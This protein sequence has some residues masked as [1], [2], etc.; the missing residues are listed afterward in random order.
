[1]GKADHIHLRAPGNLALLAGLIQMLLSRKRKTV[2]YAGNWD[3]NAK[4]PLSYRL[5]KRLFSNP[6]WCKN[7]S[8]MAYGQW[9][10]QSKNIKPFFTATYSESEK[11]VY[12][13]TLQTPLQFLFVG[14]LSQNKNPQLLVELVKSLN[15]QGIPS[16]AHFYG[17]GPM[18]VELAQHHSKTGGSSNEFRVQSSELGSH[19]DAI[20]AQI[21]AASSE[22]R[23]RAIEDSIEPSSEAVLQRLDSSTFPLWGNAAGNGARSASFTFHGNQ[24]SNVVKKAYEN[25]HFIFLASQSEGWP[26]AIAE[27]MWHGCVPIATPVSCVPWMLNRTEASS[28]GNPRGIL[29]HSMEETIEKIKEL[30]AAPALF[31]QMSKDAQQWSQQ[32]TTED[33]EK[34]I[35][36]LLQ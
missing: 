15:E 31:E 5:Q 22:S 13:K 8:V 27:G 35:K 34:A 6:K 25:S 7:T 21:P 12:S 30:M 2:K 23:E 18:M 19:N 17:D 29:F 16:Q 24:P 9:P 1:M 36:E 10:H 3:P 32:Y 33:F 28:P 14:T 26:K 4:Q 11:K 20:K